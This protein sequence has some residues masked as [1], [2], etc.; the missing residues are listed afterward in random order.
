MRAE[1]LARMGIVVFAEPLSFDER[2]RAILDPP[3][4][5]RSKNGKIYLHWSF[6]RDA[7]QCATSGV[8]PFILDNPPADGDT[9]AASL[10]VPLR[11][12][13]FDP[14]PADAAMVTFTRSFPASSTRVSVTFV[15]SLPRSFELA[16]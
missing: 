11:R 16:C 13:W 5:I 14:P 12:L 1:T 8:E 3:R 7:R 4:E 6:Y 10:C 9:V 15:P 2:G